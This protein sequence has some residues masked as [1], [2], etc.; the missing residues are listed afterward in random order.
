[1]GPNGRVEING[2]TATLIFERRL[3]H[4]PQRVW[5]ALTDAEELREWYMAKAKIDGRPGGSIDMVTGPAQFHW[6][7]RILTWE[8]FS[9]LEYEF[10]AAPHEHLAGGERSIVRYDL[11]SVAGGTLLTLIHSRLTKRTALGFAPGTHALLDR[12]EASLAAQPLPD[13]KARYDEV[14]A[15]YPGRS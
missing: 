9:V 2:E 6:T 12:L 3:S 15:A 5:R 13:W 10:N 11:Q 14:K 8:P 4:S 1:M 7:G